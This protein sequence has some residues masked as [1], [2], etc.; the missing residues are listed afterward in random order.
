MRESESSEVS[1]QSRSDRKS[2]KTCA[3]SEKIRYTTDAG[4]SGF[5]RSRMSEF[6][7]I[8]A[9]GCEENCSFL[10][11]RT[12]KWLCNQLPTLFHKSPLSL[13]CR[14]TEERQ[15]EAPDP[16]GGTWR[17]ARGG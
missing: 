1:Q 10:S 16:A 7:C 11:V 4:D 14:S 3:G 12:T 17:R 13:H 15:R 8:H 2:R 6:R 5:R 9:I